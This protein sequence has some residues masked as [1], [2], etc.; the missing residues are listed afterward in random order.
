MTEIETRPVGAGGA[1]SSAAIAAYD[2]QLQDLRAQIAAQSGQ[3][4]EAAAQIEAVAAEAKAQLAAA[5]QEAERL[6]TEAEAAVRAATTDA[7]LGRIRAALEAGGPYTGA[8]SDLTASGVDVPADVADSCRDG[9]T[10]ADGPA[11][12]LSGRCAGC[13]DSRAAGADTH[14]MG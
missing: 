5:A 14:R 6:K 13:A 11:A 3:G 9:R 10:D 12:Q 4:S 1:A 7:A 2:R 8:V